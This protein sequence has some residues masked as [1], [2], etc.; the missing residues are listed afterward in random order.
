MKFLTSVTI[1]MAIPNIIFGSFGMNV[2]GVP[3]S[4]SPY[5]FALVYGIAAIACL[6]S[7]IILR[8]KGLF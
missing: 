6:A 5:S 2:E 4:N 8:K 1:V 3:F 7:I